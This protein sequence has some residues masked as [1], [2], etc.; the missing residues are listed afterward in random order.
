MTIV[1]VGGGVIGLSVAYYLS[2]A[3]AEVIVCEQGALGQGC[4]WGSAG[5]I[6]PSESAPVVGPGVVRQAVRS[7]GRPSSP[8]YLR[9]ALDM[10]LYHWML[11]ALRYANGRAAARGLRALAGLSR[12]TFELYDELER[13]GLGAD[14]SARGLLHVFGRR[15]PAAAALAA[16]AVMRDYGYRVPGELLTGDELRALEPTLSRRAQAGYLIREERHV[17]PARLIA[18]LAGLARKAGADIRERTPVRRLDRSAGRVRAVVCGSAAFPADSVILAGGAGSSQLLRP[19]GVRLPLTAGKGYSFLRRLRVLP[20][21]PIHLGDVK[22]A[23]TPFPRGLRV[24][25]TME[26]SGDNEVLRRSRADAIARGAARFLEGWD[27]LDAGHPGDPA[28]TDGTGR[29]DELWV[30]RRPLTPDGL[31]I[32]DRVDPVANLFVATGHSM[33]GVTL[34]PAS[35]QAMADYVL[36]GRRPEQLAPFRL[37][38]F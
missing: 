22:V 30:G 13:A 26:L 38:R 24:A 14:V 8:L 36:S 34:A 21:R 11:H 25:G 7:L 16:A 23:V 6:S 29:P 17:D 15:G 19:L 37:Q 31:P 10:S 5:W 12:P 4:T 2:R 28:G 3:G 27:D 1:V 32:L 33:L 20:A 9:P 18:G 35:G